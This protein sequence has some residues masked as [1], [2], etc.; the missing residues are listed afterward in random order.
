[1]TAYINEMIMLRK[2]ELVEWRPVREGTNRGDV[3]ES[4]LGPVD[5]SS[6]LNE[7]TLG[8]S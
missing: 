4:V 5:A 8:L 1:M 6:V 3:M 2:I 7:R